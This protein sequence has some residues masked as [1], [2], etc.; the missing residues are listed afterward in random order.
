MIR[1]SILKVNNHNKKYEKQC[2][3]NKK[4]KFN[5]HQENFS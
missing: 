4:K 5:I 2:I 3:I 1:K